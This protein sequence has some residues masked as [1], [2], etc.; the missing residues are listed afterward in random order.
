[1]QTIKNTGT[2]LLLFLG[3]IYGHAQDSPSPKYNTQSFAM[4]CYQKKYVSD[5]T[6]FRK[7]FDYLQDYRRCLSCRQEYENR[8]IVQKI[9]NA[10]LINEH[11]P[12]GNSKY[13][14][15]YY[16]YY[17]RVITRRPYSRILEIIIDAI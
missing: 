16:R 5:T 8:K 2:V 13:G 9:S 1:M 14:P 15:N 12:F 10:Q 6:S 4:S 3:T 7:D 17:S 11:L